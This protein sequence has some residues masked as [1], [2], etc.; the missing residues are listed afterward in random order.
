M[1]RNA[2]TLVEILITVAIIGIITAIAAVGFVR[3]RVVAQRSACQENMSKIDGAVQ[4]YILDNN[5]SNLADTPFQ[6]VV[7]SDPSAEMLF[8]IRN[9]IKSVPRCPAEGVYTFLETE[10]D[11]AQSVECNLQEVEPFLHEFLR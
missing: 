1:K 5:L 11:R 2:F 4:N 7:I 8:G 3:A 6:G 10:G 9:Y